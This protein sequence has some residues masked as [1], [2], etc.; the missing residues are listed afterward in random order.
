MLLRDVNR[1]TRT[2]VLAER[3][4]SKRQIIAAL[5]AYWKTYEPDFP[6]TEVCGDGEIFYR[7]VW[8]DHEKV[9]NQA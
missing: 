8:R 5:E 6:L 2:V 7:I 9:Q 3:P 4:V 1:Q